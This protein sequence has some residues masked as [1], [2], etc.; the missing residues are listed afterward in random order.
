MEIWPESSMKYKYHSKTNLKMM[1]DMYRWIPNCDGLHYGSL[2]QREPYSKLYKLHNVMPHL[3]Q[4][5]I[6]KKQNVKAVMMMK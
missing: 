5:L 6:S 1:L 4:S 2:V 3:N